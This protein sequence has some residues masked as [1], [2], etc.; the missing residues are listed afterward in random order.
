MG[1]TNI[2]LYQFHT[3][4]FNAVLESFHLTGVCTVS[5]ETRALD[6]IRNIKRYMEESPF[7]YRFSQRFGNVHLEHEALPLHLLALVNRGRPR[8][9]DNSIRLRQHPAQ[10]HLTIGEMANDISR[11]S[12]PSLCIE[13]NCFVIHLRE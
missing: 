3:D 5:P 9:S 7:H 12:N 2:F 8:S 13:G 6:F 4:S 1:A 11:F 10:T